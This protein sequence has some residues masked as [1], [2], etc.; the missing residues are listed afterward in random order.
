MEVLDDLTKGKRAEIGEIREWKGRKMKKVVG[1]W[2][3]VRGDKTSSKEVKTESKG[4]ALSLE[5]HAKNTSESNLQGT[6]K[7]SPDPKLR[8]AAHKELDRRQNEEHI[9]EDKSKKDTKKERSKDDIKEEIL[10]L[11]KQL[12]EEEDF[13]KIDELNNKLKDLIEEF[14]N[15]DKTEKKTVKSDEILDYLEKS[16]IKINELKKYFGGKD[17]KEIISNL[18]DS[19]GGKE[20]IGKVKNLVVD[21]EDDTLEIKLKT[22][23]LDMHRYYDEANKEVHH[24]SLDI[25]DTGKGLGSKIF[26]NQV[27]SYKKQGIFNKIKTNPSIGT[28]SNGYYTWA[29]LGYNF[30]NTMT[31]RKFKGLVG[32]SDNKKINSVESLPELMS[33]KE[34]REFWKKNGFMYSAEFLLDDNSMSIFTLN[35]YM[36]NKGK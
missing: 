6:I 2:I 31:V 26:N 35:N 20:N 16:N 9:Q 21:L 25:K 8:E 28:D 36:K 4:K 5:D 7:N 17:D 34:G 10:N 33:F 30:D 11:K 24:L 14:Q 23:K 15:E 32:S 29:R 18:Y 27:Q 19:L 22:D 13:G 1:G 3:P 12:S